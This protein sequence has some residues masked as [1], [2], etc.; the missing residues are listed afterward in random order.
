M[1]TDTHPDYVDCTGALLLRQRVRRP[2]PRSRSCASSSARSA[3]PSTRASRS[4]STPVAGS[5][6]SSA[7]TPS[8]RARRRRV[9]RRCPP[10]PQPRYM[11]GQAVMEGRHDARRP[12]VGG[13]G[14]HAG[15]RDRGRRPTRPPPGPRSGRKVPIVRGVMGL[16]ESMALGF[17]AL[18]WS[19]DRQI[20]EEERISS[21][22]MG[23][24]DG[25]RAGLLHRRSSSCIPAFANKG[26]ADYFGV[27]GFAFHLLEG[28][29]PARDLPRLPAPHR[30]GQG[31]Q[32][33][34]P[35]PRRRA[36]GDRRVR[37]RRRADRRVGAAVHA[38][39]T[40]AAAPT[41]CSR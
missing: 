20:P 11:G 14:A 37:E 10:A 6:A 19:A 21:K 2:A 13:R 23:V 18:S 1:K 34:V 40:C 35:V 9:A 30:P 29:H 32:A 3:T 17:K 5:S 27:E 16:A 7:G 36:Q 24:D 25:R 15:G 8:P 39:S 22:A 28:V 41:S 4:S 31:H 33:R 26:V 12:H 38:P